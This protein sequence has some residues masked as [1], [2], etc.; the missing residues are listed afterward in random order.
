MDSK[1]FKQMP[2]GA[3]K[4][5]SVLVRHRNYKTKITKASYENMK[6]WSG[7]SKDG[8]GTAKKYLEVRE[9]IYKTKKRS[10]W[11]VDEMD[12][13]LGDTNTP[14]IRGESLLKS[15]VNDSCDQGRTYL[16]SKDTNKQQQEPAPKVVK[17]TIV[18]E[19]ET[20]SLED[21]VVAIL[22]KMGVS[23]NSWHLAKDV[24]IDRIKTWAKKATK[25]NVENPAAY[26]VRLMENPD[27][28]TPKDKAAQFE[29]FCERFR[30]SFSHLQS[31]K[32]GTVYQIDQTLSVGP[33][34][35]FYSEERG[36]YETITEEDE[37]V[38]QFTG[39]NG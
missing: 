24:E 37:L 27:W 34:I 31:K 32:T 23:E 4:L 28:K 12:M 13:L 26:F 29:Q 3:Y 14:E 21:A 2:A 5:L 30:A 18:T 6:A 16:I 36:R 17:Q 11:I 25:P 9:L 8:L 35:M 7:L 38:S 10:E 33:R 22:K 1:M 15:G 19:Y 39:C 20:H